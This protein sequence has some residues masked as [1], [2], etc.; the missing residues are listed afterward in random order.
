MG[1]WGT[2]P[3]DSDDPEDIFDGIAVTAKSELAKAFRLRR[4]NTD[5]RWERL[6]VLQLF[7][8]RMPGVEPD[9]DVVRVAIDDVDHVL[10]DD[11]WLAG[12]RDTTPARMRPRILKFKRKLVALE[13]RL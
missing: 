10:A 11:L 5:Q 4:T 7:L 12:W 9:R 3:K 2:E 6:G 13:R 8:E 1:V